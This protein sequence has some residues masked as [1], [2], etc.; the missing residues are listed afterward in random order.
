MF[1]GSK[2]NIENTSWFDPVIP[3]SF[4]STVP[5]LSKKFLKSL[6]RICK[7]K[8][9]NVVVLN[10]EGNVYT[11]LLLSY[12]ARK[13]P[14]IYLYLNLFNSTRYKKVLSS[15]LKSYLFKRL[16]K[17]AVRGL[18]GRL[19]LSAD[20]ERFAELLE[21]KSG[22]KFETYP[23]F[24]AL[25]Y[26]KLECAERDRILINLRGVNSEQFLLKTLLNFSNV[27]KCKL[28]VHGIH[29]AEIL[30]ELKRFDCLRILSDQL[31]EDEYFRSYSRYKR[32][33]F[34]YDPNF[35]SMQS[36]GR[37]YD[38]ILA[39]CEII[40]PKN[41][42]LEDVLAEYGNGSIYEFGNESSLAQAIMSTVQ[43]PL[44]ARETPTNILSA[45]VVLKK[46]ENQINQKVLQKVSPSK[47]VRDVIIDEL[48]WATIT[49]LH[50]IFGVRN[51]LRQR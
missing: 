48:T 5:W 2:R 31:D 7:T 6:T 47:R 8:P 20:T 35:F 27:H 9:G 13:S 25:D 1:L 19:F 34:L 26:K 38:S 32:A 29:N 51:R 46:I 50:V 3:L 41:T 21:K 40:V 23:M 36:S 4:T 24:S 37:L 30:N 18:D 28:E 42:A 10:Y 17:F 45:K 49:V 16:L 33:V 22:I 12:V 43:I 15:S 44:K 39:D 14:S 11:L